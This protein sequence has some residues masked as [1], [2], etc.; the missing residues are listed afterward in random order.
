MSCR[1]HPFTHN[2]VKHLAIY[3]QAT[4]LKDAL[5]SQK[6]FR[7]EVEEKPLQKRQSTTATF[8]I[9]D[10]YFAREGEPQIYHLL[11]DAAT[12]QLRAVGE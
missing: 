11:Q 4:L 2:N 7:D 8:L 3:R 12:K 9:P 10:Q 5:A 1:S 6:E